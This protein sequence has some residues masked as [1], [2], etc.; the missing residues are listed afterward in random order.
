M[1]FDLGMRALEDGNPID[2]P[3]LRAERRTRCMEAMERRGVDVLLLG[4]D[5][6]ARYVSGHRRLWY[7]GTRPF[8]PGCV[9]VRSTG[10]VHVS[11]IHADGVP[12]E[13]SRDQ[14]FAFA[15]S[16]ATFLDSICRIDGVSEARRVAVDGMTPTFAR[17][18]PQVLPNAEW[19]DGERLMCEARS[20]KTPDEIA[21]LRLAV[22]I[23]ESA[24][25]EV[26]EAIRPGRSERELVGRFAE[27]LARRGATI[28]SMEGMFCATPTKAEASSAEPSATLPLRRLPTDRLLCEGELVAIDSGAMYAG[29]EG[30][31][32]RTWPCAES[33]S[34][35]QRDLHA[36]WRTVM[37]ALLAACR[38][39]NPVSAVRQAH[40]ATGEPLPPFSIVY[41]MGLGVEPPLAGV[42]VD[43]ALESRWLLQPK[44]VLSLQTY[45]WQEG[46][47]GYFGREIIVVT[48]ARAQ[49]LST[50][51][52]GPLS[53]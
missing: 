48:E 1:S 20:V 37:D 27:A 51:D 32:G 53:A 15:W 30:G 38:S 34:P 11:T 21:C 14:L 33:R 43:S 31:V 29:Y 22:A 28:P 52:D 7:A 4:R 3:R 18:L 50:L 47:G 16:P 35:A 6:N 45:V 24:F 41:G 49:R 12:P 40:Q 23:S 39:G 9:V 17:L 19:S 42:H 44:N 13:I 5:S 36:R 2:F 8:S 26:V 10:E 46:V 25:Q